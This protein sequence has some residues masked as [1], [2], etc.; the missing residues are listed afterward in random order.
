MSKSCV[1]HMAKSILNLSFKKPVWELFLV[2]IKILAQK[3]FAYL[4]QISLVSDYQILLTL[5]KGCRGLEID[6]RRILWVKF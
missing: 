2:K 3:L 6:G 5:E 1:G 4:I